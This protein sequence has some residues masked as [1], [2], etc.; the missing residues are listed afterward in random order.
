MTSTDP[1]FIGK[2]KILGS[3]LAVNTV[4]AGS[5]AKDGLHCLDE[6]NEKC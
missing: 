3:C 6:I 1:K 4:T 5:C 2:D